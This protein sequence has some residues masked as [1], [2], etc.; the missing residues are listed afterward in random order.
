MAT[1]AQIMSRPIFGC[2]PDEPAESALAYLQM[3]DI[4]AAPV[5][6]PESG[7]PVGIVTIGDLIGDLKGVPVRDRMSHPVTTVVEGATLARVREIF[8]ETGYHHLCVVDDLGS[9]VGFISAIDA[10]RSIVSPPRE[11]AV[12]PELADLEW[13]EAERLTDSGLT[14]APSGPGVIVLLRVDGDRVPAITWAE[15]CGSVRGRLIAL[16][17]DPPARLARLLESDRLRFRAAAVA[18]DA[19]RR[20]VLKRVLAKNASL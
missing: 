9:A 3:L 12:L 5:L 17:D 8:V 7:R 16:R 15:T 14:A 2:E 4:H 20:R 6:D 13:T 11:P 1:A 18:D 10:L 19:A